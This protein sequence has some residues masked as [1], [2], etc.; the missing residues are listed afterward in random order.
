MRITC[1]LPLITLFV[2]NGAANAAGELEPNNNASQANSLAPSTSVTGQ[3]SSSAD[4]DWY[5]IQTTAGG[6]MNLSF[7]SPYCKTG[8]LCSAPLSWDIYLLDPSGNVLSKKTKYTSDSYA[9]LQFSVSVGA[10]GIFYIKII[11]SGLPSTSDYILSATGSILTT[12]VSSVSGEMTLRDAIYLYD[13]N[14]NS[15]NLTELVGN[16][17]DVFQLVLD[18]DSGY[19]DISMNEGSSYI[20]YPDRI[21]DLHKMFAY[22]LYKNSEWKS[23]A[24]HDKD[25]VQPDKSIG[26]ATAFAY[27]FS[28]NPDAYVFVWDQKANTCKHSDGYVLTSCVK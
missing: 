7:T 13:L 1:L 11:T 23:F 22:T 27:C 20:Q 17:C 12:P 3:L 26:S 16:N 6:S 15:S 4:Q 24:L 5:K 8:T 18:V 28:T 2:M 14:I 9:T 21:R 10:A 25:E 19:A